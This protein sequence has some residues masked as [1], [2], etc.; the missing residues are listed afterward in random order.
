MIAADLGIHY[1]SSADSTWGN[2]LYGTLKQL[3][4]KLNPRS[5]M[6]GDYFLIEAVDLSG[7]VVAFEAADIG[8]AADDVV[9]TAWGILEDLTDGGSHSAG[10]VGVDI[11]GVGTACFLEAGACASDNG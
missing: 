1:L 10:V 2:I 3:T 8:T 11:E 4:T 6:G 7:N 9:V 5:A